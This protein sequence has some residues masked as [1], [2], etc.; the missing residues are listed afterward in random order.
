MAEGEMMM[1]TVNGRKYVTLKEASKLFHYDEGTLYYHMKGH[2]DRIHR[3]TE[4]G[5]FW[6]RLSDLTVYMK[7]YQGRIRKMDLVREWW[8]SHPR[9]REE[10][11]T[12]KDFARRLTRDGIH[13][14]L[15]LVRLFM[16]KEIPYKSISSQV[17][18]WYREDPSRRKL[19]F[20]EAKKRVSQALGVSIAHTSMKRGRDKYDETAGTQPPDLRDYIPTKEAAEA[21]GVC[22][23][24][25]YSWYRTGKVRATRSG[26]KLYL[27]RADVKRVIAEREEKQRQKEEA[28]T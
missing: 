19:P 21:A 18:E 14:S 26:W 23:A 27:H 1:R 28:K 25:A 8:N 9:E 7:E 4:K 15:S 24:A 12:H 16:S 11:K 5:K 20:G 3:F 13:V 6:V 22:W 17:T 10:I 2:P